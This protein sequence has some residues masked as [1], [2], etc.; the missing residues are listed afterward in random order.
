MDELDNNKGY[1]HYLIET[2][3]DMLIRI[4]YSYM[5]NLSDAED[6]TQEVFI[7]LLEKRPDFKNGTHEKSWL[8]RVA[9]NLSK[10]KLK[11]SYF[12][13]T[14]SLEDDFVDT[15][16]ED[17][18]VIQAVLS[19]PVKYRSIVFLYYYEN[20]SISEISNILNIKESTVGSQLSRGRKLLK[21]ILKEDFEYE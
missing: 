18:D 12:K 2:Y 6:I 5:K 20:Y 17:T 8:I 3:S 7:K 16:Q 1:I 10:D 4:S 19:L 9:I 14:T 21:S 15:T 11:S 13:N